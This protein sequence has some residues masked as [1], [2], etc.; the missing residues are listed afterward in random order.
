MPSDK[1]AMISDLLLEMVKDKDPDS[2]LSIKEIKIHLH[3]KGFG[4]L[5]ILFSFPMAIP[6]PYPPGFTS[7]LGA[8]LLFFSIQMLMGMEEP[9]LP[10]WVAKQK[11]KMS[12]LQLAIKKTHKYF[13]KAEKMLKPRLLFMMHPN[14]ERLIGFIALLCSISIVLPIWFGN[15][16]PSAGILIMSLGII[17]ADGV[18]ILLGI[19]VS[20]IGLFVAT[21]VVLLGIAAIKSV[22]MSIIDF[23]ATK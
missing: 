21:A 15:A 1:K 3:E 13:R 18:V 11:I 22:L 14:A 17:G 5:M 10:K 16:I 7:I 12:H 20:I 8:P 6:L 23:F 2:Y 19:V 4:L 9:W